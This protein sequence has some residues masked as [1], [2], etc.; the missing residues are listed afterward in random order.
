MK[1]HLLF[2]SLALFLF[3][4][5]SKDDTNAA[6]TEKEKIPVTFSISDL[7]VSVGDFKSASTTLADSVKK[8]A[9]Y[10]SCKIYD[11]DGTPFTVINQ[12]KTA[13]NF[14]TITVDLPV[15]TYKAA[16]AASTGGFSWND[17]NNYIGQDYISTG[18]RTY[19]LFFKRID[20]IKVNEPTT[21]EVTLDR[22]VS[23]I[24]LVVEDSIPSVVSKISIITK[25]EGGVYMVTGN[26]SM[27]SAPSRVATFTIASSD[28][29][30]FN[31][32]FTTFALP[33]DD[34][35]ST[36]VEVTAYDAKNNALLSKQVNNV[37]FI[38]N[39]KVT[40]QG[41]LFTGL[42]TGNATPS[43][44]IKVNQGWDT[45]TTTIKIP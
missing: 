43:F 4:S 34:G 45:S 25:N 17:A 5:C 40:I 28:R 18:T 42:S 41:K 1:K 3:S 29:R 21:Q 8:H 11:K 13:L 33:N 38:K 35:V 7:N 20:E 31:K 44:S 19:D 16:F 24:D 9:D 2:L 39:K 30:K 12:T 23:G 32:T 27:S 37:P 15:G 36:S 26:Y 22:I 6:K 14:G 10:L